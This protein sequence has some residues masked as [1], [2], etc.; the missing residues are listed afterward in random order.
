MPDDELLI[1][2]PQ[3][4]IDFQRKPGARCR[5]QAANFCTQAGAEASVSIGS[6]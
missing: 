5:T 6:A 4:R 3:T 1:G 2:E